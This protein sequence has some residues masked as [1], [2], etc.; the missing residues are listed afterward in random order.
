MVPSKPPAQPADRRDNT[1]LCNPR[2]A[3]YSWPS[4][5]GEPMKKNGSILIVEDA[6]ESLTLL[7]K[8]LS[9]EGYAVRSAGSG[10]LALASAAANPP[11]L[12]LLD[13]RM[14]GVD[15]FEALRRLHAA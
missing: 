8:L 11:D 1:P 7:T 3:C 2:G 6:R 5:Q 14:P 4:G 9:A 12:I 10:D 15:G 13:I